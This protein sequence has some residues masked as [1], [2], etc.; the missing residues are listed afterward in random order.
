M[1]GGGKKPWRQKGT[2]R[3]RSG[4]NTSPLWVGGGR[5]FGPRPRDYSYTLP[6]KVRRLALTSALSARA[7]DGQVYVLENLQL[8][9]PKT[10]E[11]AALLKKMGLA[12]RKTLLVMDAYDASVY[13]S[14]RNIPT[15]TT[16]AAHTV[17]AHDL[18]AADA[19]VLTQKALAR[20]SEVFT[21]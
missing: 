4:S 20:L 7:A 1:S 10:R 2:G 21:G 11:V 9:A 14:T 15:V 13:R 17:N 5:A 16:R 8:D 18:L 12:G 6:K 3:A 19:L